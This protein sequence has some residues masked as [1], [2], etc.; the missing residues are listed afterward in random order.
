M[1]NFLYIIVSTLM[2]ALISLTAHAEIYKWTDENGKIH[3]S[4]K[5]VGEK[6]KTL[7]IKVQKA[8][9]SSAKTKDERKQRAEGFIR[10]RE[11][12]RAERDKVIAE[13]KRLKAEKIANCE[14]FKKEYKRITEA[15]AVYY[16]NK[17]GTR[18]WL[19]P[20]RRNKEE[21]HLKAQIKKWCK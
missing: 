4:D 17:D 18:D 3:F 15:G 20:K 19:E 2:L 7:D 5:P 9:P 1:K 16:E 6:A 21:A 13:K 11:E 8:N 12:E 10:A 14:K